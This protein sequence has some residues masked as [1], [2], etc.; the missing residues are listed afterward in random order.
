MQHSDLTSGETRPDVIVTLGGR[1][2]NKRASGPK[3]IFYDLK[4]GEDIIQIFCQKQYM[5]YNDDEWTF[6]HAH[7]HRGDIIG[8][9]GYPGRTKPRGRPAGTLSLFATE[10]EF[11]V[12]CLHPFPYGLKD[13]E[14][15]FRNRF[16]DW[17]FN[18]DSRAIAYKR[19]EIVRYVRNHLWELGFIEAETPILSKLASGATAKP[20]STYHN[21]LKRELFLRIAP[22]LELKKMIGGG[23]NQVFEIGKQ[24]RN[25]GIDPTHNPEFTTCEVYWAYKDYYDLMDF[26]ENLV[27]G[28][29]YTIN[30]GSYKTTYKTLDGKEF[31]VNWEKP[32][33]RIDIIPALEERCGEKFPPANQLH[34][35]QTTDFLKQVLKRTNVTCPAPLTNPRMIDALIGE[36]LE[37]ECISPTFLI[38]HPRIMSP[39]AKEHRKIPGLTERFEAFVCTKEIAN[40]YTE[41]NNPLEQRLRFEEQAAQ[42]EAGDDEAQIIDENFCTMLEWGLPPTAGWGMGIDRLVMFMTNQSTIKEVILF[43][44]MNDEN[45]GRRQKMLSSN[46]RA[47]LGNI[48]GAELMVSVPEAE[49][50]EEKASV[51]KAGQD[52]EK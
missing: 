48:D 41:L 36:F 28:L 15:R 34:T 21:G 11:L 30:K 37:P 16:L 24:F 26:T 47:Q 33:K 9:I 18:D 52:D 40:A 39:L 25:E 4:D 8:I 32:W 20:F 22:E 23:F 35:D 42:R 17:T 46:I 2:F 27:S 44:M 6:V 38:N 3:L 49:K 51:P 10:I 43:P 19:Q 1:V 12:P 14:L 45:Q 7:I 31:E 50:V 13:T 5:A 29:A